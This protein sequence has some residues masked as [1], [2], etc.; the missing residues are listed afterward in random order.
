MYLSHM[1]AKI[2]LKIWLRASTLVQL[3]Q[4]VNGV[5]QIIANE[6]QETLKGLF[7]C[8]RHTVD[9]KELAVN[10]NKYDIQMNYS[11]PVAKQWGPDNLYS[12]CVSCLQFYVITYYDW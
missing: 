11:L 9:V 4:I 2:L 1:T 6:K 10:V 8:A 3:R 12:V 7:Q 5:E